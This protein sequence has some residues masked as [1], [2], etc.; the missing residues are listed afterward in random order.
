[1]SK[2]LVVV[3]DGVEV[4]QS[5]IINSTGGLT[6]ICDNCGKP[7]DKDWGRTK[8]DDYAKSGLHKVWVITRWFLWVI[9]LL[10]VVTMA[11]LAIG[12]YHIAT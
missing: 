11:L 8:V 1:M 7:V 12:V 6:P 4:P 5:A 9:G 2:E 3:E 10:C